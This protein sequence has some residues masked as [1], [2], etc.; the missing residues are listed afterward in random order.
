EWV[1]GGNLALAA[2]E[3]RM[4]RFE[5][6]LPVAREFGLETQL[7]RSRDLA[8]IVPGLGGSWVGG[9]HTPGDGHADPEKATDAF[10]RAARAH[11]AAIH[12]ECAVQAVTTS[13]GAVS[14][15]VTERGEIRAPSVVCAA[16]AWSSRLLR[17]L[18]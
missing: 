3:T 4:A 5:A 8:T 14:G 16:G 6:W 2:D 1:P 12:L 10:A 11:G 9:M 7:V 15:V 13:A 17:T 18:G